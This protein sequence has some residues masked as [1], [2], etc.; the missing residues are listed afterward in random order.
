[1]QDI[2]SCMSGRC[3]SLLCDQVEFLHRTLPRMH[4][5]GLSL[6]L[7]TVAIDPACLAIANRVIQPRQWLTRASQ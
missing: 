7:L 5:T 3:N 2:A 4:R 6:G 1:M